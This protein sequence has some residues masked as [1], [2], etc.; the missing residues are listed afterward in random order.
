LRILCSVSGR[1]ETR[2]E[3]SDPK[4]S[5]FGAISGTDRLVRLTG[6]FLRYG[7]LSGGP[8][9]INGSGS[10]VYAHVSLFQYQRQELD[11]RQWAAEQESLSKVAA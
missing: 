10:A 1:C 5:D 2:I 3:G 4:A 9:T 8:N 11:G 6:E 7:R